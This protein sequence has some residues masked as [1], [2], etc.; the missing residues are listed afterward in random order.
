[1]R[2]KIFCFETSLTV[3]QKVRK[4]NFHP[5]TIFTGTASIPDQQSFGHLPQKERF[6]E[7]LSQSYR[8]NKTIQISNSSE[9]PATTGGRPTI[10]LA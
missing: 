10:R 6:S 9:T 7:L 4:K 8:A 1:M 3:I 5:A 2:V